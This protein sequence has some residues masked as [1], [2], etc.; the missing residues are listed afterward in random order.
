MDE[1]APDR[2]PTKL[3]VAGALFFVVAVFLGR[4][5]VEGGRAWLAFAAIL[6]VVMLVLTARVGWRIAL[7]GTLVFVAVVLG[8]RWILTVAPTGWVALALLPVVAFTAFL[9]GRVLGQLRRDRQ[10]RRAGPVEGGDGPPPG[11]GPAGPADGP[12]Q[13]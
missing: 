2:R 8:L 11:K 12:P 5:L 1:A 4:L 7:A 10:A 13:A 6:P 9:V 3:V